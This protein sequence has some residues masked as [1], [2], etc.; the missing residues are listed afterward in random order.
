MTAEDAR[1]EIRA[2]IAHYD[3]RGACWLDVVTFLGIR[4][5][6]GGFYE[7]LNQLRPRGGGRRKASV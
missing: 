6:F 5:C 3:E 7:L 1:D 2:A 4:W